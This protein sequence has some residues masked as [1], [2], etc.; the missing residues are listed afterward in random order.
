M[1]IRDIK[2]ITFGY[3]DDTILRQVCRNVQ[4][5]TGLPVNIIP[6]YLDLSEYY[7]PSRRQYNADKLLR[8]VDSTYGN[9]LSKTAG[10]F[11]A[12]LFI[13]IL[14][15][16]FG[17]A[18]LKGRTCITSVF[19]LKNEI[20]GIEP[21]NAAIP[22]RLGKEIIHELGH[23]FG[24]VHCHNPGCV[25]T[26]STYLEDIDQ[27]NNAYCDDCKSAIRLY[28]LPGDLQPPA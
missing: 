18:Y 20:Y 6:G 21:D 15:F 3:F 1:D 16:I 13:P 23:C 12:D 25:M 27:K 9:D 14:T 26:S 28:F 11:S 5:G 2:L 24:L 7:D 10:L 8:A 17:Q 4:A 19:R 22:E